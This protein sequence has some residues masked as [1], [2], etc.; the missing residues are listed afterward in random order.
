MIAV[1]AAFPCCIGI[2]GNVDGID[3]VDIADLVYLVEFQFGQPP[4]PEAPCFDE[5]NVD[6]IESIDIGDL[7][8]LVEFQFHGGPAPVPCP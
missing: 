7:V 2:R 1:C 6:G 4:G 3:E 8:Y 5:G